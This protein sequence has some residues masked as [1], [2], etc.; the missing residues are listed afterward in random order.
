MYQEAA[1]CPLLKKGTTVSAIAI[2]P[3]RNGH[4]E[5]HLDLFDRD[6]TAVATKLQGWVHGNPWMAPFVQKIIQSPLCFTISKQDQTGNGTEIVHFHFFESMYVKE[7][8]S[9]HMQTYSCQPNPHALTKEMLYTIKYFQLYDDRDSNCTH[10][11]YDFQRGCNLHKLHPELFIADSTH[12]ERKELEEE[13]AKLFLVKQ[14]LDLMKAELQRE[15][16]EFERAKEKHELSQVDLDK[17]F[18]MD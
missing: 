10:F 13:K 17:Y 4:G 7:A 12:A 18:K 15:R 16:L 9:A 6:G 11:G 1:S 14:K 8:K 5:V 2:D 3:N